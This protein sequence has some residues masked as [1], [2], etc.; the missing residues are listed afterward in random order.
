MAF[1]VDV[2]PDGH[3]I[4]WIF[5]VMDVNFQ[6]AR[7]LLGTLLFPPINPYSTISRLLRFCNRQYWDTL[8][9]V[10]SY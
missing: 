6:R 5:V 8:G 3:V 2:I 1:W 7:I 9:A 10:F 4:E